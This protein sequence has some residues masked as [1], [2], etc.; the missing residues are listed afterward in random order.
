MCS[1]INNSSNN[2]DIINR[3]SSLPYDYFTI[4][5]FSFSVFC[6]FICIICNESNRKNRI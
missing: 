1:I 5:V 4:T 6:C 2:T 3:D